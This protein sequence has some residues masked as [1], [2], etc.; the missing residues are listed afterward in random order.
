MGIADEFAK[1]DAK[2]KNVN[3][4]VSAENTSGELV[5]S[6]W[7]HFFEKPEGGKIK[8][9]DAVSRWSGY[10]NKEFRERIVKAYET[11]QVVRVVIART[12]NEDVVRRGEDASQLK[13]SF[14]AKLDWIGSITNWDGENFTI[15]FQREPQNA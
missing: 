6:L 5:V 3:W 1:F 9:V 2:L 8:Y 12:S 11:D 10:G 14:G 15:E 4:S 13:N 7:K